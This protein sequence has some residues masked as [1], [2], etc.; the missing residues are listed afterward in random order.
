VHRALAV[1]TLAALIAAAP[2]SAATHETWHLWSKQTSSLA[3]DASGNQVSDA[4]ATPT[5]GF[6][7]AGADADYLGDHAKH[8][9]KVV[10]TDHLACTITQVDMAANV[11]DTLCYGQVAL[12]GGMVL[13]DHQTIDF[14]KNPTQFT[15]TGGTGRY[16]GATGS[17][18]ADTYGAQTNDTDLVLRVTY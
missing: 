7:F 8:G 5:V 2:A 17:M 4:N 6:V 1:G 16:H 18:T 15:V 13:F 9:K 14:A 10:A 12:P 3:F 11:L